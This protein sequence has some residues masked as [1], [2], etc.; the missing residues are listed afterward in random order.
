MQFPLTNVYGNGLS[1][2]I[3]IYFFVHAWG[4]MG[5]QEFH[6]GVDGLKSLGTPAVNSPIVNWSICPHCC[7]E[8]DQLDVINH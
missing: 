5:N 4:S 3:N 1:I 8:K 2:Y 6:K 7:A